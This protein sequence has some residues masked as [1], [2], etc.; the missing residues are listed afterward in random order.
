MTELNKEVRQLKQGLDLMQKEL[1]WHANL[2]EPLEGDAFVDIVEDLEREV[3]KDY[4]QISGLFDKVRVGLATS[5][6]IVGR[7][8]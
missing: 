8:G 7:S 3:R 5:W 1:K 2:K 4:E 6:H